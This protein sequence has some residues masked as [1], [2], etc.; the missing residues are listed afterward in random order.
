[1]L[2]RN[3][4]SHRIRIHGHADISSKNTS[5]RVSDGELEISFINEN[6][7]Q[8]S[9]HGRRQQ[10]ALPCTLSFVSGKMRFSDGANEYR[11]QIIFTSGQNG[12]SLI[13]YI[14]LEDYLRG[15]LPLEIGV[16]GEPEF[17]ALKAQAIAARTFA[18]SRMLASRNREFDMVATVMDQVYGGSGN[19]YALSD[20]AIAKT[21]GIVVAKQ[22][23]GAL[24]ETFFHA[25]CGGQTAAVNEVW[26]SQPNPSLVSRSDLDENGVAFC[27]TANWFN[28]TETWSIAQFSQILHKYSRST[29]GEA[30][31]D[32]TVRAV[33]IASRTPSGRVNVLEIRSNSGTFT[34]GRDRSRFVLRRPTRDE[35]I[36]RSANFEIRIDG[37][38][39][40]ATGRGFGHGIGMCQ[41]GALERARRG[42]DFT[43]ILSAYYTNIKLAQV[44]DFLD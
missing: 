38:Q 15:V 4:K 17:E 37:G 22:E 7:I 19:E 44:N 39:V 6:T 24:L 23:N 9:A 29:I 21:R 8:I 10:I 11:G 3:I 25:I 33:N 28:W 20:L 35:G 34:Y 18:L 1:M 16:R 14:G 40:R 42:Q 43:Q 32:G 30:P 31:F 5:V 12:F 41:N 2:H 36:L 26:N 13:N 27:A